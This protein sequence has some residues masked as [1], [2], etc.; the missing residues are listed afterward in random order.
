MYTLENLQQKNLKELKEIGWELNVS[1]DGDRRCR[2]NWIDALIG[3]NPPLLQLLEVSPVVEVESV[4]EAIEI[5][6]Q[7]PIESKFG[8][9]VYPKASVK[10][11][12]QTA[13]ET[14]GDVESRPA[15]A[16]FHHSLTPAAESDGDS[17]SNEAA[18]LGSQTGDRV[19][20][21][22]RNSE[23]NKGRALLDRSDEL[24]AETSPGVKVETTDRFVFIGSKRF[25]VIEPVMQEAVD[26]KT[27]GEPDYP[28][29]PEGWLPTTDELAAT[30]N[31]E[32]PPNRG[33]GKGRIEPKVSQ[34]AIDF[35]ASP[36]TFS[37]KF[38]ATYPPYFG[39]I[40]YKADL[41]G[42][43]NLLERLETDN[44]PPDPDDFAS[45][46][47][48][49][50]AIALWDAEHPEPLEISL[51]SFCEWAP[52]PDDWYEPEVL[53]CKPTIECSSTFSIPTFDAWCDRAKR[54]IDS[55]EPPDTGNYA[56]L[57]GPKPPK[58]PPMSVGSSDR[59]NRIKK[60]ARNATLVSGRA[61]PGGDAMY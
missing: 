14:I 20:A 17:S 28:D 58:F 43:L 22:A 6:R 50:E 13:I 31:D 33:D 49:R 24:A 2:Q 36:V 23:G 27:F 16:D 7:E 32:Q 44:E 35:C 1:P 39:E 3:K 53:N 48:F 12:A 34:S 55:D 21:L 56:R 29:W 18:S 57:P 40:H 59:A 61:P 42:Q 9:I 30:F 11:I 4:Q 25:R 54:Q 47:A 15:S 41:D 38:L 46:D 26:M 51:D 52:C 37:P 5:Q 10:P 8:C 45:L 19:L 60:F